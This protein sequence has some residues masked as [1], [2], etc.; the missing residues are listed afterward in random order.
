MSIKEQ[1]SV[2]SVVAGTGTFN[3]VVTGSYGPEHE[4]APLVD[5]GH[6]L[7]FGPS[8][9]DRKVPLPEVDMLSMVRDADVLIP[10]YRDL[11]TEEVLAASKRLRLVTAPFIG[12]DRIDVEA[13]TRLGILVCNS[14]REENFIGV[15]EATIGAM[16]ILLKR[17]R[18]IETKLRAGDWRVPAD[19]GDMLSGKT[20]G[21]IGLGRVGTEVARRLATWNVRLIGHDPYVSDDRFRELEVT[22]TA[23]DQF[24]QESDIAGAAIDTFS[25]EP[26]PASSQL[27]DIDS[28]RLIPTG[29]NQNPW[30]HFR[31]PIDMIFQG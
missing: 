24:L 26:L 21:I 11:V 20:V 31:R 15:A 23:F 29:I 16:L 1:N 25:T 5:A 18:P 12:V 14:P 17:V 2:P 10:A 4:F 19:Y 22:R 7:S 28:D 13:A 9:M 8:I 3:V 27:R 30:A 6:R